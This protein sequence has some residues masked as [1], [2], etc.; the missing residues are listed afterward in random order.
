[1]TSS[2]EGSFP[3]LILMKKSLKALKSPFQNIVETRSN[4]CYHRTWLNLRG[5]VFRCIFVST[6]DAVSANGS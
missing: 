6:S 2:W 5:I 3:T 4:T 1:M